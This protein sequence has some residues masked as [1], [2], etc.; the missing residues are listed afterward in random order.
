MEYSLC[1]IFFLSLVTCSFLILFPPE[2]PVVYQ[3]NSQLTH[4]LPGN[5]LPKAKGHLLLELL[6]IRAM[7]GQLQRL[8]LLQ[9]LKF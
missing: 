5:F 1:I 6:T 3:I 7:V 8:L 2:L 9:V 4:C